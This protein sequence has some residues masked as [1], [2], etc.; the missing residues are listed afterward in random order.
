MDPE[1]QVEISDPLLTGTTIKKY[2]DRQRNA[3]IYKNSAGALVDAP[4][5]PSERQHG[6]SS[7]PPRIGGGLR[8]TRKFTHN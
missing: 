3:Y 8:K 2:F 5:S 6:G 7:Q 4:T 1:L